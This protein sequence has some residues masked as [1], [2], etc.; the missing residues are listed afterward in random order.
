MSDRIITLKQFIQD[1][2]DD[3]FSQYAL[4]LELQKIQQ[5]EEAMHWFNRI[6]ESHPDYL[7]VYYHYGKLLEETGEISK[8]IEIYRKGM[9][10]A[11]SQNQTRTLN[12]LRSALEQIETDQ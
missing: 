2:P 7:P 6:S 4:A 12:E 8:A 9:L 3:I 10:V 5:L 11:K 1:D